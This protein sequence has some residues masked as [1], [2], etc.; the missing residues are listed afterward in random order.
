LLRSRHVRS[1]VFMSVG[2]AGRDGR[3][4]GVNPP[5]GMWRFVPTRDFRGCA[6]AGRGLA[7]CFGNRLAACFL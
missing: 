3:S 5:D 1:V 4:P 6:R 7:A 2:S